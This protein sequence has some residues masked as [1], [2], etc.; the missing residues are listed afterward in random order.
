[1]IREGPWGGRT[2]RLLGLLMGTQMAP[3]NPE[4]ELFS[5]EVELG[6][7]LGQLT[8]GYGD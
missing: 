5:N 4:V 1:M 7:G 8:V 3:L 6:R 2:Y